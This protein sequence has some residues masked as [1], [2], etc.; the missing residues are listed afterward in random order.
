MIRFVVFL[1]LVGANIV[2]S[3]TGVDYLNRNCGRSVYVIDSKIIKLS[4]Y[5]DDDCE[6]TIKRL[7]SPK[8][9]LQL[10]LSFLDFNVP[11]DE[12]SVTISG[13][14]YDDS[15]ESRTCGM[16]K[17]TTTY[18]S[19]DGILKI[20]F[21]KEDGVTPKSPHFQILVTEMRSGVCS[22]LEFEC[23]N[24]NCIDNGLA[25]DDNDNCGDNSDEEKGCLLQPGAIAGIVIG[26][27]AFLFIVF[28]IAVCIY[29]K[30]RY[31][32]V[33]HNKPPTAVTISTNQ[34]IAQTYFVQ[35][36]TVYAAAPLQYNQQPLQYTQQTTQYNMQPTTQPIAQCPST[37][38][39]PPAAQG[40]PPA[41]E[42]S[43]FS[44][45]S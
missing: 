30:K 13:Y 7:G 1:M 24:Y 5:I 20:K 9:D 28:C 21:N 27:L 11:C 19:V 40:P 43:Q 31:G 37:A 4:G 35:P 36:P 39:Y 2:T 18:K 26:S 41:Y 45:K 42:L 44:Q 38:Q 17:P 29:R 14:S 33:F 3:Y 6:V 22:N 10:Q 8:Y 15:R 32:S 34:G 23:N 16:T 12:G 25:C